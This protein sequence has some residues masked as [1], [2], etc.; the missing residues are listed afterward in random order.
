MLFH[1]LLSKAHFHLTGHSLL[2][3]SYNNPYNSSYNT[4]AFTSLNDSNI[5]PFTNQNKSD[6]GV[7]SYLNSDLPSNE[8]TSNLNNSTNTPNT[9]T[10][11]FSSNGT[12]DSPQ[13]S[14]YHFHTKPSIIIRRIPIIL[15]SLDENSLDEE[16]TPEENNKTK[17]TEEKKS[18]FKK[19]KDCLVSFYQSIT[20]FRFIMF[21]IVA[22]VF[23][24]IGYQMR[25][26][27]E[28]SNY[29]RLPN[30]A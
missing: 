18:T 21:L 1:F 12:V 5:L 7:S 28:R 15:S 22:V 2:N 9:L 8:Q 11:S 26:R 30:E 25:K 24:L 20:I 17:K 10:N 3:N 6:F 16:S 29:V 13:Q 27:E 23:T 4:T 19:I 14:Y